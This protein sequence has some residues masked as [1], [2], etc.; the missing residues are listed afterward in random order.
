MPKLP[1]L[2]RIGVPELDG[3]A[4][5]LGLQAIELQSPLRSTTRP[6]LRPPKS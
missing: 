6:S 2:S 1:A 5:L 3:A 4:S